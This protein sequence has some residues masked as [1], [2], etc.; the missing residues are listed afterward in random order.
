[1]YIFIIHQIHERTLT[2]YTTLFRSSNCR[3]L[4]TSPILTAPGSAAP[5]STPTGS[6]ATGSPKAPTYQPGPRAN[7]NASKTRSTT[8]HDPPWNYRPQPKAS[9]HYSPRQPDDGTDNWTGPRA[10][11]T[12]AHFAACALHVKRFRQPL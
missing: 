12:K 10:E 8:D 5:T 1:M 2:T 6:C 9:A 7:S 4:C 11:P 3:C